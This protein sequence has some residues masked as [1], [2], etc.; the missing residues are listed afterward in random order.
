MIDTKNKAFLN[1]LKSKKSFIFILIAIFAVGLFLRT[2]NFSEWLH[3]ELDQSRDAKVVGLAINQGIGNLP[4]LGPKAAGSFLRLGPVFYYFE[5]LGAKI[6]GNTPAGMAVFNLIFSV[7]SLP[8]FYLFMRRYFDKKIS[9]ALFFLFSISL[10]L[11]MYSRFAWNPNSLPF[12]IMLTFYALLRVVDNDEKKKGMWLVVAAASLAVTTQLHFVAFLAIPAISV[13]FL[14][15]KRPKIKLV[16]WIAAISL[17]IFFYIPPIIND[18]KTGGDNISEFAKVFAKKSN[19]SKNTLLEKVVRSYTENTLGYFLVVTSYQKSELPRLD[20]SKGVIDLI[21]DKNCKDNLFSGF[22]ALTLFT[23]GALLL[24]LGVVKSLKEQVNNKKDFIILSALWL[25]VSFVLFVP[26]SYDLAPRFF[27]MVSGLPFIFLGLIFAFL[28][29]TI[30]RKNVFGFIF[31]GLILLL[32][33]S[34]LLAINDRFSQMRRASFQDFDAGADKI[35]K[36]HDRV[37]LGQQLA[38]TDYMENIYRQN[39]YPVYVN[40]EAFY[41]RSF[42]YHLE[43]RSIARDDFRNTR[44]VYAEGNFFLIYPASSTVENISGDYLKN[45]HV[46]ETRDFG[47]LRVV[48]LLPNPQMITDTRQEFGPEKKPTSASGV[49]VRCR[50]NEIFGKCNLDG[51]EAADESAIE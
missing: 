19:K 33:A 5:Y 29:D 12:F 20:Q 22:L 44:K 32:S 50:W 3:F 10:F 9:V 51:T 49:P 35:L 23:S 26:I 24:I 8:L 40:S 17:F 38:I 25:G 15:I 39:N 28:E 14:V 1:V 16:Y 34:N 37:T 7:L 45:Y 11:I 30:S 47:T 48:R 43:Q 2:Y 4:L 31:L 36:E 46:G 18:I 41:R 6:F 13:A 42:L 27:L 21:C